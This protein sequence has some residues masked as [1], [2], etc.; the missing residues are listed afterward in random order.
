MVKPNVHEVCLYNSS[1][2]FVWVDRD[3]SG[4]ISFVRFLG[5][6]FDDSGAWPFSVQHVRA[7]RDSGERPLSSH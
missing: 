1:G 7:Q 4:K 5:N 2:G 6:Q 3:G